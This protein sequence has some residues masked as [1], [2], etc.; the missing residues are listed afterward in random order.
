MAS[1]CLSCFY[2]QRRKVFEAAEM[3]L[4]VYLKPGCNPSGDFQSGWKS[5][6]SRHGA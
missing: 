4:R 1:R 3:P 5:R 2:S 6:L